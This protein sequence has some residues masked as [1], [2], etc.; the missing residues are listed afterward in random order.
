MDITY[1]NWNEIWRLSRGDL[2]A[3]I[4]LTYAQTKLYNEI[5]AKTLM[6]RLGINHVPPS[7]FHD[8]V[9]TQYKTQLVCNYKTQEPQSY[10]INPK[11]L[12][13][14]VPARSKA[15]YIKA[16]GMR[17]VSCSDAHIPKKY[18]DN[19]N[20]NPFV[21]ITEDKIIFKLESSVMRNNTTMNQ[22]SFKEKT[23]GSLG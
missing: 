11:F 20:P 15:V 12:F 21:D 10:F 18:F 5:S 6:S 23:N 19:I 7:L 1:F 2:A 13:M 9:L 17:R 22:R 14:L 3:I 16:L 4:I 8:K